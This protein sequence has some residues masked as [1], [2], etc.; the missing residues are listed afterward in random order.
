MAKVEFSGSMVEN[1]LR[2][3]IDSWLIRNCRYSLGLPVAGSK[4][5]CM[6]FSPCLVAKSFSRSSTLVFFSRSITSS[7]CPTSSRIMAKY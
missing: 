2:L 1:P 6:N 7:R 5:Y 4:M 3:E